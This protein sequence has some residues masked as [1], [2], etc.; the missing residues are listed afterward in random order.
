VM[1][2]FP[3][4][5]PVAILGAEDFD[6][7]GVDPRSL[8]FGPGEASPGRRLR[9]PAVLKRDLNRDGFPDLL[10]WFNTQETGIAYG[11]TR[12]CLHGERNDGTPFEGCDAIDTRPASL[13]RPLRDFLRRP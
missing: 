13:G 2:G 12:A 1:P 3:L 9:R 4:P 8:R 10:A 5:V 6:V 11:E 7:R